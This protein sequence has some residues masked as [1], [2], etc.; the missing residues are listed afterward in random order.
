MI[1]SL[2]R[3]LE[4]NLVALIEPLTN[5]ATCVANLL[6]EGEPQATLPRIVVTCESQDS[7]DFQE[8]EGEG[9]WGVYPVNTIIESIVE[10][11]NPI[12]SDH[13]R[14]CNTA[15]DSI[16]I[17]NGR[18]A[19][20]LTSGDL[21]VYGVVPNGIT[22]QRAGN[23]ISRT[24]NLVIWARIQPFVPPAFGTPV[25]DDITGEPVIDDITGEPVVS[26]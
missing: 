25:I 24:R 19:N 6:A 16:C 10:A 3:L 21:K 22:Q 23:R 2:D 8:I 1:G 12:S 5:T 13:M 18:L 17:Y 7:L 9:I 4:E 20:A 15:V 11:T 26:D 14:D